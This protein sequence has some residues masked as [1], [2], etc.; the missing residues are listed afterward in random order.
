MNYS[1][2]NYWKNIYQK[3]TKNN[4]EIQSI[5]SKETVDWHKKYIKNNVPN[6]FKTYKP[7]V[8][9]IGC[10]S[11]YLT[12]LFCNFSSQV[13]G[14]DYEKEFIAI[15]K[16]KYFNP[17]FFIAD[18]YNLQKIDGLFDLITCFGV[19]QNINDLSAALKSIKSKLSFRN[20]S[21]IIITTI[22]QNSIFNGNG[23]ARN[24]TYLKET[25]KLNFNTFS[26]EQFNKLS[27]LSGLKLTK[28]EYLYIL[29]SILKPFHFIVKWILP[30]SFSHHIL[31]EMQH[32][33]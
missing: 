1:F 15:A 23:Y 30:K 22:N 28:Y 26:M 18:I 17:K 29:P 6:L 2:E 13:V 27:E 10:C 14:I 11:G 3:R 31:I 32:A 4:Y 33:K 24:F 16:S 20:N 19:I 7:K 12:N 25:Q 8:L 9:D 21:R 5:Q